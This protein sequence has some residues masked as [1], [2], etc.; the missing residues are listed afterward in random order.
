MKQA[1]QDR[2]GHLALVAV[3]GNVTSSVG[4]PFEIV[5][6]G[7]DALQT[8]WGQNGGPIRVSGFYQTPAFPVG[9][10]PD[11]VNAACSFYCEDTPQ[12]VLDALHDIEA[13]FDR[14]RTHR[15]GARTLDLDLIAHGAAVLP[16]TATF[17][18]WFD[19]ELSAQTTTAP[20]TLILP[21]PRVQDRSFVLVPLADVAPDWVH[22]R[23][24]QT[25]SQMLA[26]RPAEE[27]ETVVALT[28]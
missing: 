11:F 27:R 5:H 16:D 24:G 21:H 10:G 19:L 8:R 18:H 28:S 14:K 15:W 20:K 2:N 25:V 13:E 26:A 12:V 7:I 3:G 1:Y 9:A 17:D 6:A 4:S 23:T 22:P